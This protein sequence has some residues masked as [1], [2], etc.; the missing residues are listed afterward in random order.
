MDA[1]WR[2][3]VLKICVNLRPVLEIYIFPS[4]L[5]LNGFIALNRIG[6]AVYCKK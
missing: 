3:L 6:F 2:R 4:P 5:L 1:D